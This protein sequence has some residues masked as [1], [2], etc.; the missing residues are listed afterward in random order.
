[1][2]QELE[3]LIRTGQLKKAASLLKKVRLS[4]LSRS[5]ALEFAKL[6]SRVGLPQLSL[7]LLRPIVRGDQLL[8][9]ATD[10]E[11][12]Q[13]ANTLRKL[14]ANPEAIE[15]LKNVDAN[16]NPEALLNLAY[17]YTVLWHYDLVIPTLRKY[18]S[19]IDSKS[20]SAS[21]AKVNLL[22]A[23]INE[24]HL[25]EAEE[26]SSDLREVLKPSES[27][28]LLGNVWE[29]SA[30][31]KLKLS[32]WDAAIECLEK[33]SSLLQHAENSVSAL[34]IEKWM[35]IAKSLKK[36]V[37]TDQLIAVSERAQKI[38]QWETI[39]DCEYYLAKLSG[40]EAKLLHLYF[41][42]PFVSYRK[43]I[44]ETLGGSEKLPET[45]TWCVNDSP[46]KIF[47][48]SLS[49][50]EDQRHSLPTGQA[51]HRLW[52]VLSQDFYR[53]FQLVS[54]FG[55]LFPGD[56]FDP[57]TSP[58]R[59]QLVIK[60]LRAWWQKENLPFAIDA[61]DGG[62]RL[63]L[64]PGAAIKVP[65][66]PLPLNGI[67]LELKRFSLLI[68]KTEFTSK[69]AAKI[70]SMSRSETHRIL[71]EAERKGLIEL[72]G[73]TNKAIYQKKAG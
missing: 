32:D 14:G 47:D 51:L 19:M 26:F 46:E 33:A 6:A 10:A 24:N 9:P 65:R 61:G 36:G 28:L 27:A 60:R 29:L 7:K 12:I 57:A 21:V 67:E 55:K 17:C 8:S 4:Q 69:E 48:L 73:A 52:I 62:F 13:Y 16:K 58:N 45:Y 50:T 54:L 11:K 70:L 38:R 41:G 39:R 20:Y 66:N 5:E 3:N 64:A 43:R 68:R 30:Q 22:A 34:F 40:D 23:L 31:L 35:A 63:K 53:P 56:Y 2:K 59:T 37:A 25:E 42:T 15:I 49:V 1:M 44:I 71:Q 18:L 72:S